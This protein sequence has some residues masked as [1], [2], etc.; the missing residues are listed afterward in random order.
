[1]FSCFGV[2]FERNEV[3]DLKLYKHTK[4]LSQYI[5]QVDYN[6]VNTNPQYAIKKQFFGVFK[7]ALG[8]IIVHS[9]VSLM[10]FA[11]K[12]PSFH[13]NFEVGDL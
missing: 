9:H 3:K 10:T 7:N 11:N 5:K 4:Y 1:M 12:L 2:S 6:H 8:A 13:D